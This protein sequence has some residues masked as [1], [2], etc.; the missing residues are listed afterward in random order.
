M[1]QS[2]IVTNLKA[3]IKELQEQAVKDRKEIE[4]LKGQI[5]QLTNKSQNNE[6]Q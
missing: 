1:V 5:K 6:Q 2:E 4:K 3:T